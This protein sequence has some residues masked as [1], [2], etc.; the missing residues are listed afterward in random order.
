M[1][2][3]NRTGKDTTM[4]LRDVLSAI[5]ESNPAASTSVSKLASEAVADNVSSLNATEDAFDAPMMIMNQIH[6]A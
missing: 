2:N 3:P 1:I 5:N 4:A 6:E